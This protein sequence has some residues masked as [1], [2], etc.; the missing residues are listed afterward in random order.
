MQ[1]SVI[2]RTKEKFDYDHMSHY[3][4]EHVSCYHNSGIFHYSLVRPDC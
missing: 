4:T 3:S 2:H 1:F